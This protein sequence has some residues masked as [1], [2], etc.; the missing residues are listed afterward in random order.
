MVEMALIRIGKEE[1]EPSRFGPFTSVVS[2]A[3]L[4]GLYI[5]IASIIL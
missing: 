3:A 5:G 1:P 2:C 4:V